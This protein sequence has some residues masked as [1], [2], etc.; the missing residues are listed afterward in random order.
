MQKAPARGG[1]EQ[2]LGR[3][4]YSISFDSS[5][6]KKSLFSAIAVGGLIL[7]EGAGGA[8]EN[9]KST[10][11]PN[12]QA[13]IRW[14]YGG[15]EWGLKYSDISLPRFT[16]SLKEAYALRLEPTPIFD[17]N[18]ISHKDYLEM[19]KNRIKTLQDI[20]G[21]EKAVDLLKKQ[22][23]TIEWLDLQFEKDYNT[24]FTL[25]RPEQFTENISK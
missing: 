2:K 11:S 18:F 6:F 4:L 9:Y 14:F 19:S 12:P 1:L 17:P 21:K 15:V 22:V 10:N 23:N 5:F 7:A 3:I 16:S 24:L 8:D 13:S 20:P 25:L